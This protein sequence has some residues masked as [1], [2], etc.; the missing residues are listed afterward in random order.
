[1]GSKSGE[2]GMT[3]ELDAL[4]DEV[5]KAGLLSMNILSDLGMERILSGKTSCSGGDESCGLSVHGQVLRRL[6]LF[7]ILLE[8]YSCYFCC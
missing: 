5:P 2:D 4:E 7:Y 6:K 1:M 3:E 8:L